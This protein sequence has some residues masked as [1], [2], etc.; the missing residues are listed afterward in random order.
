MIEFDTAVQPIGL[1][2]L[3]FDLQINAVGGSLAGIGVCEGDLI[4]AVEVYVGLL[5]IQVVP[6][7]ELYVDL[8]PL[9]E[10]SVL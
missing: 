9:V 1:G 8:Q 7:K 6:I 5:V 3:P 2:R 4:L 10:K